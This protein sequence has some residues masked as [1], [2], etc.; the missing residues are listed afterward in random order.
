MSEPDK[1][2][3]GI[4]RHHILLQNIRDSTLEVAIV[5]LE[6]GEQWKISYRLGYVFAFCD[7]RVMSI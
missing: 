7:F 5:S 4:N 3:N 2:H 6:A 1:E